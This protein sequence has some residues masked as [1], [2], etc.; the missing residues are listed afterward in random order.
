VAEN[1]KNVYSSG[2]LKEEDLKK[3]ED[4]YNYYSKGQKQITRYTK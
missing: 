4:M 1:Y 2:K 3:F